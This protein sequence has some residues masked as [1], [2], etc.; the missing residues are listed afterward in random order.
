MQNSFFL[1]IKWCLIVF[2]T[3]GTAGPVFAASSEARQIVY[4]DFDPRAEVAHAQLKL[5]KKMDVLGVNLKAHWAEV[6]VTPKELRQLQ[7]HNLSIRKAH[8]SL[9]KLTN[10]F[11]GYL[12]PEQVRQAL[13]EVNTNYPAITK[14]FEV[15]RTHQNRPILALE[16][17]VNPGDPNKPVVLFNGMHHAREVMTPEVILHIAKVLTEQ[18]GQ[19]SKVTNWLNNF[20]IILVPQVN[21]DGNA[22]VAGG[23]LFWRKNTYQLNGQIVG[24]DLNRN[25]PAYW[26][27]C[28]GSSGNPSDEVYRGPSAG[29]EPE[30]QAMMRLVERFK[31]I[32]DI[33]Y[34]SFSELILYP[35]GCAGINNPSKDLFQSIGKSMNA[36]LRNDNNQTN[37]YQVGTIADVIYEADGSDLDWQWKE[38]GVL[39]FSIE[40]NSSSFMPD[41]HQWRDVT[42][43]RQE[44]G[45]Q[46]LLTRLSQS[47]F[48]AYIETS[49]PEELRYSLKKIEGF[50]KVAFD[51]DDPSRTFVLR[52]D[53]GLLYQVTGM[54]TYEITFYR[55][56]QPIKT[57]NVE[58]GKKMVDLGKIIL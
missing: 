37:A 29:S 13:T 39:A 47:G 12:N 10:S 27:Y 48:R 19:D 9:Q 25:Y 34:H 22:L 31:P 35:N 11:E 56:E 44:G 18:Y 1:T 3:L 7:K 21:P 26:N 53:T 57:I 55:L 36:K 45:W 15:G 20:R 43:R 46:A 28:D 38:H 23:N 33:S 42:V 4:V 50:Q 54:G 51:G 30:T 6:S 5:L 24:V 41:Y 40:V 52:S 58:I 49:K 16:V 8:Y 2:F 32:A 17:S 14:L